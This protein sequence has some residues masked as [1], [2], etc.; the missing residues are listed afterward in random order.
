M[1]FEDADTL[2]YVLARTYS[3]DFNQATDLSDLI[4]KWEHHRQDRITKITDF[5]A[6]NGRLRKSSSHVYEQVAKEWIIWAALKIK[7]PQGGGA[8]IFSYTPEDVLAA[9]SL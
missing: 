7:G 9:I 8:W 1:A 4:R 5:T 3:P 6:T 2:S